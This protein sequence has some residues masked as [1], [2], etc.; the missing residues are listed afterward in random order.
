MQGETFG[1]LARTPTRAGVAER[2]F[3]FPRDQLAAVVAAL[4]RAA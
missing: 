4:E 3:C 1:A 2:R